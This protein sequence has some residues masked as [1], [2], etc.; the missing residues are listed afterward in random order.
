MF[1]NGF[2][3]VSTQIIFVRAVVAARI[4]SRSGPFA[5][6]KSSPQRL[7]TRAKRRYVPP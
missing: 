4:A 3:G 2:V 6:V 5:G 1:S 7:C